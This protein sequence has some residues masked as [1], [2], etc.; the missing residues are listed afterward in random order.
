M[1]DTA[2]CSAHTKGRDRSESVDKARCTFGVWWLQR[3][4][5]N[6]CCC[7]FQNLFMI[8]AQIAKN[9]H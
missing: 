5:I 7:S 1:P 8:G 4:A 2:A 6:M 9:I 3:G